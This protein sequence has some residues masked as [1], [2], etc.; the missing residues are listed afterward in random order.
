MI[1]KIFF[2]CNPLLI[3]YLGHIDISA[4]YFYVDN[5]PHWP[6]L[7]QL[8]IANTIKKLFETFNWPRRPAA[9]AQKITAALRDPAVAPVVDGRVLTMSWIANLI[10]V[11]RH[12][13]K[14][15]ILSRDIKPIAMAG[16]R[17]VFSQKTFQEI[18][19]FFEKKA[20]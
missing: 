1:I 12:K 18:S 11:E 14:Y 6:I 9:R 16:D 17:P 3:I 4:A 20:S 13:I 15:H 2:I 8:M 5:S 19:K 7:Y 10:G